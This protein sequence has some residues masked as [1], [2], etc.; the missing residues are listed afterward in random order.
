MKIR[1][2][3]FGVRLRDKG[4]TL[5]VQANERNPGRYVVEDSRDGR[6]TRKRDHASL[7]DA[8]RDAAASW[9]ERLN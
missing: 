2:L 5:R 6:G 7:T 9:R 8:L 1:P 4:R 3:T